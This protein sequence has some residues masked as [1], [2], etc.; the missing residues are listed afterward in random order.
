MGIVVRGERVRM[1]LGYLYPAY[2]CFKSVE[3]NRPDM[4]HLRFWCQYW[5]IIALVTVMERLGD[6]LISWLPMYSEAKLFFII[7][8]WYPKTRGTTYIY[9]T[10]V[11]PFVA[12][13]EYEI[14]RNLN[15][16]RTRAGDVAFRYWQQ[17]STYFQSRFVELLQYLAS[18]SP[19]A[20]PQSSVRYT[21]PP[22]PNPSAMGPKPPGPPGSSRP[23]PG[24][25]PPPSSGPPPPGPPP[26]MMRSRPV[27]L[28]DDYDV[29]DSH[30]PSVPPYLPDE[31]VGPGGYMTRSRQRNTANRVW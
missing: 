17:G 7:Y 18:Q 5:M 24:P 10:F 19:R 21:Y 22:S 3:K 13:H 23:P 4:E 15:E 2:E 31:N 6:A 16:L 14:D 1:V 12:Q 8:L 9:A 29:V 20:H 25:P 28:E 30:E 11:R 26:G 27:I